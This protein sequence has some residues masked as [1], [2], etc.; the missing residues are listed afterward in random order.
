MN[1]TQWKSIE[2]VKNNTVMQGFM[3]TAWQVVA[4]YHLKLIL[5]T[6]GTQLLNAYSCDRLWRIYLPLVVS[7]PKYT[8]D[9]G[10]SFAWIKKNSIIF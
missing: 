8:T 9:A 5:H 1:V 7:D 10:A 4:V 3:I 6:T 2:G